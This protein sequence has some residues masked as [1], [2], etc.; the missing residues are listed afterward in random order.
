MILL[1]KNKVKFLS[2]G[3]QFGIYKTTS[4][5][6]WT[7]QQ[8]AILNAIVLHTFQNEQFQPLKGYHMEKFTNSGVTLVYVLHFSSI[9][10]RADP[11]SCSAIFR[12]YKFPLDFSTPSDSSF[13]QS[14][15]FTIFSLIGVHFIQRKTR[16][17]QRYWFMLRKL[18]LVQ[19]SCKCAPEGLVIP[20]GS[21]IYF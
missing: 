13:P 4:S 17:P 5:G 19:I 11:G 10:H 12:A 18:N 15:F 8:N 7:T 2:S 21:L 3:C 9:M 1:S 20:R 14:S 16:L 6:V